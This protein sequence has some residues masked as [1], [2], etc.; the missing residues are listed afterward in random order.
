[1]TAIREPLEGPDLALAQ[2]VLSNLIAKAEREL[3][4]GATL[5]DRDAARAAIRLYQRLLTGVSQ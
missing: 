3:A 2:R 5:A 4:T 1:M